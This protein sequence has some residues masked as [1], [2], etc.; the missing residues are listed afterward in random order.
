MLLVLVA[1][2]S[3]VE[4]GA[5]LAVALSPGRLGAGPSARGYAGLDPGWLGGRLQPRLA[6]G[7]LSV[8]RRGTVE[9]AEVAV[10][11]DWVA[12]TRVVDLAPSVRARLLAPGERW[13]P[14]VEAGPSVGALWGRTDGETAAVPVAPTVEGTVAV[15]AVGA[16]GLEVGVGAARAELRVGGSGWRAPTEVLGSAWVGAVTVGVGVRWAP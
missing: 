15:G 7:A 1:F 2:A 5:E 11:V 13:S 12:H 4:L 6:V 3:A 14:F 16:V 10:P 8:S 9:P